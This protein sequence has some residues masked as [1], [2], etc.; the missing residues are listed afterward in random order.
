MVGQCLSHLKL[1]NFKWVEIDL[2]Q[3][4]D[5]AASKIKGYLLE[6]DV[7]YPTEL[8]NSHNNLPFMCDKIKINKVKKL[9]P[10]LRNKKKY[11]I[12]IRA[13]DQVLRHGLVLE[14]I[15]RTIEFNQTDWMKPY[16]DFNTKLR[17]AATNDFEK[18]FF[19]LMNNSV[20][21]KTMENIRKHRNIKL[22]TNKDNYLR[23]VMKPNF[24]SGVL[25]G[26]NLMGCGTGLT[27]VV[28]KKP[29]YVYLGQ[30]VLD[31]S[32]IV[33]YEF[34]Y[35]YM[36]PKFKDFQLCYM[37]TDLLVYHIKTEDFYADIVND[38][39]ERF[40]TS[41]YVPERPLPIGKN[42]KVIRLM[43]DE[44]GGAIITE[45]VSLRP[46]LYSY[47][48]L[49]G[50][51]DKKCKGIKKCVVKKTLTF[52][53]YK[54]CLFEDST[55]YRSQL[56]FRSI[57]HEIF[58]LEVNKVALNKDDDNLIAKRDGISTLARGH[59]DLSWS[60]TLG[61]LFLIEK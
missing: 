53:D 58:T 47:K 44:L 9:V 28:M 46:K 51:E 35:D 4:S 60:S 20:F 34:H 25:F 5:L 24:K 27:K 1:A 11:L 8:H 19:K 17:T 7:R 21:G 15:H 38:V 52:E 33:M 49:D 12:H 23:T 18:D 37:D 3:I 36:K 2:D 57:R 50:S 14:R 54:N 39:E 43:K 48:K 16:T 41:G 13:L 26:E 6:V 22:V 32:K 45:F 10:N 55:E 29:V 61:E 30:T 56:I 40:D 31:L 59:K 42:K